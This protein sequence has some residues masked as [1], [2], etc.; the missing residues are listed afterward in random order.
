M[1]AI[2]VGVARCFALG[3]SIRSVVQDLGKVFAKVCRLKCLMSDVQV[4]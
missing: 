4:Q 2:Y 3:I 1:M